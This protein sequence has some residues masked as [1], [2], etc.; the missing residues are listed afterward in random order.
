VNSFVKGL[1]SRY[2]YRLCCTDTITPKWTQHA[3]TWQSLKNK[4]DTCVCHVC[5]IRIGHDTTLW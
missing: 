2:W 4:Y 1:K 3:G 5:R